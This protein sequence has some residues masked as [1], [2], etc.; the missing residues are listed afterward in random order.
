MTV[1]DRVARIE[2]EISGV[3]AQYDVTDWERQFLRS[4]ALRSMVSPKQ[5]VIL[6]KIEAK[7]FGE[8]EG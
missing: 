2:A 3:A 6:V 4:V 5:E 1:A 7:V 8:G